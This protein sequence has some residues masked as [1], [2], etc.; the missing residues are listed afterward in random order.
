LSKVKAD[1][2]VGL[3]DA[4][5]A[6][7]EKVLV[8]L[9][10]NNHDMIVK[11]LEKHNITFADCFE[12]PEILNFAFKQLYGKDYLVPVN[13]IKHELRDFNIRKIGRFLNGLSQ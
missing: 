12:R 5:G 9:G 4:V 13:K 3:R 7:V 11:T 10:Q 2:G 1:N 8:S 6:V